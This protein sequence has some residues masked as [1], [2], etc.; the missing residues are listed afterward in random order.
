MA[1]ENPIAAMGIAQAVGQAAIASH[2]QRQLAA[3]SLAE[4]FLLDDLRE[5]APRVFL[6]HHL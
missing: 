5:F 6:R 3:G 2:V 1:F 4:G